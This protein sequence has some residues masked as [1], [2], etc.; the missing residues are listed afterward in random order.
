METTRSSAIQEKPDQVTSHKPRTARDQYL[1][2]FPDRPPLPD[3]ELPGFDIV[4]IFDIKG[5]ENICVEPFFQLPHHGPFLVEPLGKGHGFG[6][7][8]IHRPCFPDDVVDPLHSSAV[9]RQPVY[10]ISSTL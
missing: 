4:H 6:H 5:M 7:E 8:F 3:I 2:G 1:H 9:S 10:S